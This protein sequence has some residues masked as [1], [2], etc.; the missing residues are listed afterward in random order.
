MGG[1]FGGVRFSYDERG[2]ILGSFVGV[3]SELNSRW[4][5]SGSSMCSAVDLS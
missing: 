2:S 5:C 1:W 4:R 3:L